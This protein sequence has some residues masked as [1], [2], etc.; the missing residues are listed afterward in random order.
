MTH[1]TDSKNVA[2]NPTNGDVWEFM[3]SGEVKVIR[4]GTSKTVALDA[5][6]RYCLDIDP[7]N[8]NVFGCTGSGEVKIL[9]DGTA[10]WKSVDIGTA[11]ECAH[12]MS[13]KALIE[14][15]ERNRET[16]N[17]IDTLPTCL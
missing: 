12:G 14:W 3:D 11:W 7:T 17:R 2:V 15:A 13:A 8:S 1:F 4:G 9:Q 10:M 5:D 6:N 16:D